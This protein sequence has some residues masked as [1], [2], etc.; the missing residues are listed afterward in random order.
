VIA[1][2]IG[3]PEHDDTFAGRNNILFGVRMAGK[4]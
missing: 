1:E 3:H 4:G 2:K